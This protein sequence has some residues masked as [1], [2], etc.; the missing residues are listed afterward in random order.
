M[1]APDYAGPQHAPWLTIA[2]LIAAYVL[3]VISVWWGR[4]RRDDHTEHTL[5]KHRQLMKE[6]RQYEK[7]ESEGVWNEAD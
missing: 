3:I 5:A 6:L 4:H 7:D 2:A 1:S